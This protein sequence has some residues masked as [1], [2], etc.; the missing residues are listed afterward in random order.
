MYGHYDNYLC[1][2]LFT[3]LVMNKLPTI[4]L[5]DVHRTN[6][7]TYCDFMQYSGTHTHMCGHSNAWNSVSSYINSTT[8]L[9]QV[10]PEC[11]GN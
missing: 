10:I 4:D 7:I 8:L 3:I 6:I 1:E 5:H 11:Y 9:F 2:F